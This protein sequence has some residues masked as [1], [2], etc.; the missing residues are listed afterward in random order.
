MTDHLLGRFIVLQIQG[1]EACSA[2]FTSQFITV[3]RSVPIVADNRFLESVKKRSPI[4]DVK[5]TT[6]GLIV[7]GM[8]N[9]DLVSSHLKGK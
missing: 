1:K 6:Q 7:V 8:T 5:S 2:L 3:Q 9:F 4:I